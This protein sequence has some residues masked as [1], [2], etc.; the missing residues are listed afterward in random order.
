[1][2]HLRR[3]KKVTARGWWRVPLAVT[4]DGRPRMGPRTNRGKKPAEAN[5]T[6]FTGGNVWSEDYL[7]GKDSQT[8]GN[9]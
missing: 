5:G 8:L 2:P 4:Q 3:N 6:L 1:M 9:V 7:C